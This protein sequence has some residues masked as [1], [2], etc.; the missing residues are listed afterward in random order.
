MP[1]YMNAIQFVAQLGRGVGREPL[2][3]WTAR[4]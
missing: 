2:G 3:A 1:T 4:R